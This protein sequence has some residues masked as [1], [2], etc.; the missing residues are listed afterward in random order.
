MG[1]TNWVDIA[2]R[3]LMVLFQNAVDQ[4]VRKLKIIL[5]VCR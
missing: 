2:N 1:K 5:N 4:K 3:R